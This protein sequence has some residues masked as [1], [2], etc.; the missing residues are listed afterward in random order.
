MS[1]AA[2]KAGFDNGFVSAV[3][4]TTYNENLLPREKIALLN[5]LDYLARLE[6][7]WNGYGAV[8]PSQIAVIMA[9]HFITLL[10]L[11]RAH[12][13]GIE[14][15]GDGGVLLTWENNAERI[16]LTIDGSMLH[17]SHERT[18]EP[19]TFTNDIPFFTTEDIILP[20]AIIDHIPKTNI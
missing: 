12:A 9:R 18:G 1:S 2:R 4:P 6:D 20:H 16:I 7:N 17:L 10:P 11:N 13:N 15:D 5:A 19:A 14:P 8:A 3:S